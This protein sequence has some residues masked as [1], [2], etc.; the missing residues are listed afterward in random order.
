MSVVR[1]YRGP[2]KFALR[3]LDR[4]DRMI[5]Q[6]QTQQGML[7]KK[8]MAT[9]RLYMCPDDMGVGLKSCVAVY[10]LETVPLHLLLFK[11]GTI[12][13]S[14]WFWKMEELLKRNGKGI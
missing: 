13:R 4:V 2:V 14:E 1:L 11:W 9:I 6:H 12:F 5:R 10:L 8:G 3:W 7:T